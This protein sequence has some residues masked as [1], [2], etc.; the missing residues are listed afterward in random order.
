MWPFK[1]KEIKWKLV[2]TV[3]A[4]ITWANKDNAEDTIY[5]YLYENNKGVRKID[6]KHTNRHGCFMFANTPIP[7][8]HPMYL[9]YIVPWIKGE[10]YDDIPTY[11]EKAEEENEYY[12]EEL[13]KRI[14][15]NGES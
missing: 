13:Y 4:T 3:E 8:E 1:K 10:D 5:Y 2:K 15:S 6:S 11:W 12:I 14:L 9:S 7:W